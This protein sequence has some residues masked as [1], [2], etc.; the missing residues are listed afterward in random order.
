MEEIIEK[1]LTPQQRMKRGRIMKRLAKRIQRAKERKKKKL[2]DKATLERRAQKKA[3]EIARQKIMGKDKSYKD[4]SF[5]QKVTIDKIV[6][7]RFSSARLAKMAKKLMPRVRKAEQE[8]LLKYRAS[9]SS[10]PDISV[11]EELNY[12]KMFL[13]TGGAG[14]WGMP[15]L[16][17]RYKKDT[18]GQNEGKIPHAIDPN[19]SLKHAMTDIGLD[20]DVDGD[21][22]ILDK[23]VKRVSPESPDEVTGT[24]K[25]TKDVQKFWQKT[26]PELEKKHT[27]K[28]VAYEEF[29]VSEGKNEDSAKDRIR[30]EKESDKR[31]HD[32]MMDRAR[33]AD[34]REKNMKTEGK[35]SFKDMF[36]EKKDGDPCWK[37]YQQVGMKDKNGKK[38]PNCVPEE[39]EKV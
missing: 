24:E 3:K 8:R 9:Q 1:P 18:P 17:N 7:K 4:L 5:S 22:D 2:A 31:K 11:D 37:G 19:K 29:V 36:K 10:N 30:R 16:T 34:T 20:V 39:D 32:A 25:K 21:V 23:M 35:K 27:K 38:V 12:Q 6:Q 26:R 33:T 14:R 15:E 13:E 28:G